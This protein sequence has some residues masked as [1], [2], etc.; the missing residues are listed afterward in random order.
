[1]LIAAGYNAGP[2]RPRAWISDLGDPRAAGID[3]VDWVEQVPFGETRNYIM[4]VLEALVIYRA[5]LDGA[6]AAPR[7]SALLKGQ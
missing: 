5:R 6:R 2:G 4:R 3:A 7:L 1:V